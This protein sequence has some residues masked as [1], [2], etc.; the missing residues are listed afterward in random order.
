[1]ALV[2]TTD[3]AW[4]DDGTRVGYLRFADGETQFATQRVGPVEGT[5]VSLDAGTFTPDTETTLD[6]VAG[7]EWRPGHPE[8]ALV[9]ADGDLYRVDT[10]AGTTRPLARA[11]EATSSPAWHPDGDRIAYLRD[12]TLW[13]HGVDG[14]V[15]ALSTDD[16]L[17]P[18]D[19]FG[20]TPLE[21]DPSG[22][23]VGVV[24]EPDDVE[25]LGVAVY[26]T[27]SPDEPVVWETTPT[28]ADD[29]LR[30]DF[31][32][33]GAGHLVYAEDSRDGT[34]RVY[35]SVRVGEDEGLGVAVASESVDGLL[36]P[37]RPVG[38]ES[39]RLA[40]VSA[41]TG[42]R[43]VYAIDVEARRDAVENGD[44]RPGFTGTGVVQVTEG[45]FEARG[46]ADDR[47]AW[48]P[49]GERLAYVTNEADPGERH[50][51]V[52]TL[53]EGAVTDRTAFSDVDG[54][55]IYPTWSPTSERVACLRSGRFSPTDVHVAAVDTGAMRRVSA[56]YPEP[57]RLDGLPDPEPVSFEASDGATVYGYLYLPPDAE[58]GDDVPSVVLCHGG[59]ISQMRRG[60]HHGQTYGYFHLFDQWFVSEGY[61]VL[62]LNF[63]SGVGYGDEFEQAIHRNIG[64][65]EIDDCEAAATYL[66]ERP[67]TSDRVGMWG[68]SYG[69]YL[70]NAL[71]T[72]S[73]EYDCAVNV[74]GIWD[75]RTWEEWAIDLGPTHW[76]ASEPTW[77]HNR[78]GGRP[79]SD[80]PVV[81]ERY[82]VG[83][84]NSFVEDL[85]TP[86]L[87]L[88][89][90]TDKNVTVGELEVLIEECVEAGVDF[91]AV[92]YPNEEHMFQR[93]ATWRDALGRVVEFFDDHLKE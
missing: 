63:R 64:I 51:E 62:E 84:P 85:D 79:D 40:V 22:R 13:V 34:E 29:C 90:S 83:S 55:A 9:V 75:W 32:W 18:A 87:A 27:E 23:Y 58:A 56:S 81:Q 25:A 86:L 7:F 91:D 11:H 59:P 48:S 82:R 14:T 28:T 74:A 21:W 6:G 3:P 24:V 20:P 35:R 19:L 50:L 49:D 12:R 68:R 16:P 1:M 33:V 69:G 43:H 26:D 10:S 37:H 39:G 76:G 42:W 65:V 44:D 38:H 5:D 71:A 67:E 89:G 70:A 2:S 47:P 92:Y 60:F 72:M 31:Q 57:S 41:R 8:E 66:R 77:F 61:A 17:R 54:N 46:D 52:A 73:D 53:G 93:P 45:E 78:F 15:T 80:D 88:H 36:L 30:A 4:N